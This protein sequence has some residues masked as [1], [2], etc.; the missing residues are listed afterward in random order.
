MSEGNPDQKLR[1]QKDVKRD[2][3]YDTRTTVL[4]MQVFE[5]AEQVAQHRNKHRVGF[6]ISV[7]ICWHRLPDI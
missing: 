2:L 7:T 1:L 5:I 6:G 3:A 4:S